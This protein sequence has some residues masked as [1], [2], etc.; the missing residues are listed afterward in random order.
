MR[1]FP[2]ALGR[3]LCALALCLSVSA[4]AWAA[5][6]AVI[7]ANAPS[8]EAVQ[9]YIRLFGYRQM[10]EL[11]AERQLGSVIELVRETHPDLA[12]GVLDLI[13]AELRAEVEAATDAAVLEMVP[14]FQR[15]LT[16]A[17][18]AYLLNVGRDPRMQKVVALQPKI[19]ED[20]EAVGE[21][22]AE[23]IT[24]KAAPRI[25]ERLKKLE[26]GQQL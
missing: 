6:P 25:A 17:D 13:H 9:E 16:R 3:S 4:P 19:A 2:F 26:G 24:A 11:S 18:V 5:E 7:P 23:D 14:V 12:P 1:H 10:L 22:L 8:S 21:H 20:M 15:H